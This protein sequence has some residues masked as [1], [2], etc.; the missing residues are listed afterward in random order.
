M[1]RTSKNTAARANVATRRPEPRVMRPP[2]L[3]VRVRTGV[4][5]GHAGV[6]DQHN[7]SRSLHVR[8]GVKAGRTEEELQH[9]QCR[10]WRGRPRGMADAVAPRSRS[11]RTRA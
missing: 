9:N 2:T 6:K 7:Q 10:S 11:E 3:N 8:T 4:K 1:V 5:A